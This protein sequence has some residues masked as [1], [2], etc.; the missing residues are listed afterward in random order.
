MELDLH[1][2]D[3]RL[4]SL[5]DQ[6]NPRG[7][8]YDFFLELAEV[9]NARR[10][11]DFGCGTGLLAREFAAK[12]YEVIGVD[13]AVA[14]LAYARKQPGAEQIRWIEGDASRLEAFGADLAYMTGNVAQ[15]FQ[16]DAAWIEALAGLNLALRP[17]GS[18]AFE[19]RNPAARAWEAWGPEATY[20]RFMSPY[21]EMECWLEVTDVTEKTVSF[22]GH[23][24]FL[25]TGE[26][27]VVNSTLRFRTLAE[28]QASLRQCGFIVQSCYGN[29][30]KEPF[31]I[32]SPLILVVCVKA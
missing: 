2:V 25:A 22:T 23:N 17:G 4:V 30:N 10:V 29:W 28:I 7:I 13:P 19:S 9:N 3:P 6:D 8:D 15:V 11:L 27:L 20:Q 16:D 1:Y 18:L 12:G 32:D 31:G 14:M 21:G 26:R 24:I 5:Y